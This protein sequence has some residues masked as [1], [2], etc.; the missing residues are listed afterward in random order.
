MGL[1]GSCIESVAD[2]FGGICLAVVIAVIL[3]VVVTNLFNHNRQ[4]TIASYLVTAVVALLLSYQMPLMLGAFTTKGTVQ[5]VESI[6][7]YAVTTSRANG[8]DVDGSFQTI[9]KDLQTQMPFVSMF[10][11]F[12]AIEGDT[13][14]EVTASISDN[15]YSSINWYIFRRVL[16][17]LVIIILGGVAL[18]FTMETKK[19][20]S[21][22]YD[23]D[24]EQ[25]GSRTTS[26]RTYRRN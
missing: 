25:Y 24:R 5:D 4:L 18:V 22:R 2:I 21:R 16:W 6:I 14:D 12:Q 20:P 19:R 10:V 11:D 7:D 17:S 23:R 26:R 13:V 1:L 9:K 3:L 8:Y 15:L